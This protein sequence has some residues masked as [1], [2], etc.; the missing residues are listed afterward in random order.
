MKRTKNM[1]YKPSEAAREL[2]LVATNEGRLY[3]SM[4]VP[5]IKNLA[6]KYRKGQ[7][8]ANKAIDAFWYIADAASKQYHKDFGYLFSVTER[9]TAAQDMV[10]YFMDDI[11]SEDA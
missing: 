10:D 8:D 11:I 5:T 1:V 9:F 3:S 6:K 2:L 4:I 7:F